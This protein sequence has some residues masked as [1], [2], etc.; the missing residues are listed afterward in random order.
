YWTDLD[1][2]GNISWA[3]PDGETFDTAVTIDGTAYAI[4]ASTTGITMTQSPGT[5]FTKVTVNGVEYGDLDGDGL[6]DANETA[7]LNEDAVGLEVS[8]V[9]FGY[10][11]MTPTLAG[12]PGFGKI[13]PKMTAFKG[14]ADSASLV[15]MEDVLDASLTNVLIEVNMGTKWPSGLGSARV[16][17]QSSFTTDEQM[18]LFDTDNGGTITVGELRVLNGQGSGTGTSYPGLYVNDDAF[19]TV[20]TL[21]EIISVLDTNSDQILSVTEAQ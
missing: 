10:V 3:L 2:D 13:L 1:G 6:V 5:A 8:N 4:G 18:N 15:G 21:A 14:T 19:D 7:E 20:V 9:D 12:L 11:V 17:F 16:N